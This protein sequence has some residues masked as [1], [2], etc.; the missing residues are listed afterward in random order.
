[1][2]QGVAG[3]EGPRDIAVLPGCKAPTT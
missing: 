1:L 2:G 3:L